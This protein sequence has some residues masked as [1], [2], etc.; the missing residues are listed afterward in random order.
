MVGNVIGSGIYLKPGTI[1]SQG[2]GFWLIISIW[3][4][5]GVLCIFGALCFAELATML[6]RAG[7]LYVYL[8]EA[9]G[10]PIAFLFGWTDFMMRLPGSIAAL[11]V[12]FVITLFSAAGWPR[13]P[14]VEVVT[15]VV[16]IVAMAWINI[17]GVIW[18]GRLQLLFTAIKA[19]SLGLV[20]AVPF[21]LIPFAERSVDPA[22]YASTYEAR[23]RDGR[24]TAGSDN[25]ETDRPA[26]M[27]R[28]ESKS[29][30]ATVGVILLMVMWAYNGW[31]GITPLAEEVRDPQRNIPFA[32]FGGIGVLIVLYLAANFAYHGVLSMDEMAAAGQNATEKM[33]RTVAGQA[34]AVF[35]AGVI[36]FSTF[37]AINTNFLQAPRIPFAMGR[38]RVFFR[39]LG[40][41]H[42]T[43]RTPA[44]AITVSATLAVALIVAMS[45]AK[46]LVTGVDASAHQLA[47]VRKVVASLQDDSIFDL[48]TN[49]VI[50]AA[51]IYYTL[52]VG[53]VIILRIR[54]PELE[55]PYKAW[56]Y[57]VV[58]IVFIA[59]YVWFLIQVYLE[60]PLEAHAGLI[61]MA[62][63]VPVFLYF[64]KRNR[65]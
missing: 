11:A 22:N 6:P 65:Q 13:S 47:L 21:V 4:G 35:V 40:S 56:G 50:F 3:I 17:L 60:Q 12:A 1:A 16:L 55:R 25:A 57:P 45:L 18:G 32:L 42:A 63:G 52:A 43:Y 37:G 49:F 20:A 64:R 31:H 33:L 30:F 19:G 8:R 14:V 41:V 46:H 23:T 10:K 48:L 2:A 38:D 59:V 5:G 44:V 39:S 51:S 54:R 53:A 28:S 7:G 9:Y 36:M 58:P 26:A 34:G 62:C 61:F 27:Y 29:T 24:D 15:A